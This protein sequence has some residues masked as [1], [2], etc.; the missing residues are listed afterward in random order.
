MLFRS[1]KEE[2][3]AQMAKVMEL[4]RDR[5]IPVKRI[6]DE[7]NGRSPHWTGPHYH[8]EFEK[9]VTVARGDV[10]SVLDEKKTDFHKLFEENSVDNLSMNL[11]NAS[12]ENI[13]T[14]EILTGAPQQSNIVNNFTVGSSQQSQQR[15]YTADDD[16]SIYERKIAR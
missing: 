14:N 8:I 4:L 7:Y 9:G 12:R 5:G 2:A 15:N 10:S 13:I 16:R 3:K 11:Q 1:N 6:I